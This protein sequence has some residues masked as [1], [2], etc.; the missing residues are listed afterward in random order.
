[1]TNFRSP[2]HPKLLCVV[3]SKLSDPAWMTMPRIYKPAMFGLPDLGIHLGDSKLLKVTLSTWLSTHQLG[4]APAGPTAKRCSPRDN[5]R[6]LGITRC[7]DWFIPDPPT[8]QTSLHGEAEYFAEMM[9]AVKNADAWRG[10]AKLGSQDYSNACLERGRIIAWP[11]RYAWYR[12]TILYDETIRP[13]SIGL[14]HGC[15]IRHYCRD[16]FAGGS[17]GYCEHQKSDSQSPKPQQR[18]TQNDL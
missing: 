10:L 15:A 6:N 2:Q 8:I 7:K 9:S 17:L 18:C 14:K 13:L 16:E 12:A 11:L 3:K 1:M 4:T 5:G